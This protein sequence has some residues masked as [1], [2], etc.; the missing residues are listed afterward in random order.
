MSPRAAMA[1]AAVAMALA[2]GPATAQRPPPEPEPLPV[3]LSSRQVAVTSDYR[4]EQIT[5]FG[6]NP[7]ANRGGDIVIVMR[8]PDRPVTLM[9]KRRVLGLWVNGDPVS[10]SAAP[11]FFAVYSTRPLNEIIDPAEIWRHRLNATALPILDGSTPADANPGDYR[12]ALVALRTESGLYRVN[13]RG[14]TLDDDL[15]FQAHFAIPATAP[16]G[17][18]QSQVLVFRNG[19]LISRKD[20][21]VLVDRS[22]LE[23]RIYEFAT[24]SSFFYGVVSVLL[25]LGAGLVAALVFRRR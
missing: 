18:Y 6:V 22:G 9:R 17:V 7:P 10:F 19:V 25:A 20:D 5:V 23:R 1:A 12:R 16:I 2:V 24:Q 21:E 4:G 15:L 11:S 8:G 14:V 13:P 3:G